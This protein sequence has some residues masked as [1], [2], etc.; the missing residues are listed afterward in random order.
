MTIDK[1]SAIVAALIL[2]VAIL[3]RFAGVSDDVAYSAYIAVLL[4]GFGW[5]RQ[6]ACRLRSDACTI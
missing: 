4:I 1:P 5:S 3:N 2:A 6:Q